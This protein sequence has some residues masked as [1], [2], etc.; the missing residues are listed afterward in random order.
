MSKRQIIHFAHANGFPARTYTKIFSLLEKDFDVNFIERHAHNPNFPVSE[1]WT[2]LADELQHE[3]EKSYSQK[4]I[5]VGHSLGGILHFLVACRKPELYQQIILLDAPIISRLSSFGLLV[6]KKIGLI[7][8][9]SP[10]RI[11]RTR[12]NFWQTKD[13]AF[14]HFKLKPKFAIFD[15]DCLRDYI[16]FGTIE[17]IKGFE[18]FFKPEIEA[19]IYRTIPHNLSD[20]QGKLNVPCAFLGGKDSRETKL[21]GIGFMQNNFSVNV[22]LINGSHLFPFEFPLET[23]K[24]LSQLIQQNQ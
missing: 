5:G 10:S 8:R 18:L 15:E 23:V 21:A 6:A 3:I 1:G 11:T 9:F 14:E 17:T 22:K 4:I 12:K 13:E 2:F 7:D 16:N 19:H 20:F 24:T